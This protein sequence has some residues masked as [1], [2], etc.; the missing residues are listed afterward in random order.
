MNTARA[1]NFYLQALDLKNKVLTVGSIGTDDAAKIILE[2]TQQEDLLTSIHQEATAITGQCAVTVH[3]ADR[4]CIAVLDACEAFPTSHLASLLA[5]DT[6]QFNYFYSTGFFI[7]TNYEALQLLIKK[8]NG[9]FAFNFA[10]GY[11]F[12][13]R[14][15]QMAEVI[16]QA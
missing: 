1:A 5:N 3:E 10:S 4:T 15:E 8:S 14:K 16:K 9:R 11:L 7:E 6:Y 12:E 13:E 2:K